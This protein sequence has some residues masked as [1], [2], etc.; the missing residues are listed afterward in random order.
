[1]HIHS[2]SE[3]TMASQHQNNIDV[4]TND[5][6]PMSKTKPFVTSTVDINMRSTINVKL[7]STTD[8]RQRGETFFRSTD[9]VILT[10]GV[11]FH[12]MI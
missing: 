3:H 2:P 11:N 6:D 8:D 1:M 4:I 12:V 7:T 9:D 5:N 10:S